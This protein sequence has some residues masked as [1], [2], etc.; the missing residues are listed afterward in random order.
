MTKNCELFYEALKFLTELRD[1]D[2]IRLT[3]DELIAILDEYPAEVAS[4]I[5]QLLG[6]K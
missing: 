5:Y 4:P 2:Y 6:E 3:D 1:S